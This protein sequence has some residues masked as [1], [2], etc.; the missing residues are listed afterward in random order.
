MVSKASGVILILATIAAGVYVDIGLLLVGGITEI[1]HGAETH[2]VSGGQIGWGAA[3]LL[4]TGV[5]IV[6]AFLLCALWGALFMGRTV[7]H[8]SKTARAPAYRK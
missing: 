4:F 5:G 3:H 1:V 6:A 8:R 2:P 7:K